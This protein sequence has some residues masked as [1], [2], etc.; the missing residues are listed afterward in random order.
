VS[1]AASGGSTSNNAAIAVPNAGT[2]QALFVGLWTAATA[3]TYIIGAPMASGVTAA[4]IT[5]AIGAASFSA[6]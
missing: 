3:G 4:S 5:F 2:T 6:S 1:G